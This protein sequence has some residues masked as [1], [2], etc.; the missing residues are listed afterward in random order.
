MNFLVLL[1]TIGIYKFIGWRFNASHDEW[2]FSLNRRVAGWFKDSARLSLFVSLLLP[3][4][5][6]A[7]VLH[8]TQDWLFGLVGVLLQLVI[9]FYALGRS[10][11]LEQLGA[12]LLHWRSG[13]FQ[14]AYHH[15]KKMFGT[16]EGLTADDPGSLHAAVC[17]GV[18]YQWFEQVFVIIFWFLLAGPLA[19]LLIRLLKLYEQ[20]ADRGACAKERLQVLHILEW[21]PVR[22]LGFTYAIAGNFAQCF[23]SLRQLGLNFDIEASDFLLR[24]GLS[25]AGYETVMAGRATAEEQVEQLMTLQRL[26]VRCLIVCLVLVA[27]LALV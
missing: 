26:Q 2:F 18:L 20:S 1:I 9:L 21:L 14:S 5:A 15:A 19:A 25:A 11:L 10:N 16:E 8:I 27:L 17:R 24:T 23:K 12:Y 6:V 3:L 13:D 7:I 4:M 22:L